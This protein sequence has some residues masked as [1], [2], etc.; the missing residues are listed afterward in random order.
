MDE[1]DMQRRTPPDLDTLPVFKN[2][3]LDV[4][5]VDGSNELELGE[6][7]GQSASGENLLAIQAASSLKASPNTRKIF[8]AKNVDE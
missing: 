8:K 5:N 2:R 1:D 6:Q 4:Q 7:L 3:N